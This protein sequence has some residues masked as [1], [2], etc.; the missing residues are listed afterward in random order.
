MAI[1][2]QAG[3]GKSEV[4]RA[5][6][7]YAFQYDIAGF[8]GTASYM[9]RAALMMHKKYTPGSS[10]CSFYGINSKS[11]KNNSVGTNET[12]KKLFHGDIKLLFLEEAGTI[13][14][15]CL[16]VSMNK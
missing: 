6:I 1:F 3:T 7:W 9:W 8:I 13:D 4:M 11:I 12:C 14:L 10:I 16:K 15:K 2:G 5:V